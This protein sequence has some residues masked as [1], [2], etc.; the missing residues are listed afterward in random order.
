MIVQEVKLAIATADKPVTKL[1]QKSEHGRVIV[2]GLKKGVSL[3]EHQTSIPTKLVVIEGSIRYVQ[4][5][6]SVEINCY[7]DI[8]IPVNKPHAVDALENS[9]C[10]LIQG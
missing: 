5:N 10:F 6:A 2:L 3:K 4:G 9:I 1:L 8:D 7:E